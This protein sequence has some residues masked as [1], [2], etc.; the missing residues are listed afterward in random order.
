M[1]YERISA[2]FLRALR[3]QRSQ[4]AF[5]RRLGYRSNVIYTWES[6][7]GFPTAAKAFAAARR[8]GIEPR[9]ALARFYRTPPQWLAGTDPTTAAGTARMLEDLKGRMSVQDFADRVGRN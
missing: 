7:R 9:A 1:D 2:E 6:A 3:A 4:T 5:A 8:I